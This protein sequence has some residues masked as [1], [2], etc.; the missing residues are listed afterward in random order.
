VNDFTAGVSFTVEDCFGQR[1]SSLRFTS[2]VDS[3]GRVL[4]GSEIRRL[5]RL[6]FGTPITANVSGLEFSTKVDERGRFSVPL[7]IRK[8]ANVVQGEVRRCLQ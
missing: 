6:K 5:L 7:E 3:K 2:K 8:D 4:I 1:S